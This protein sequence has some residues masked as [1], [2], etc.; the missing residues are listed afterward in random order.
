MNAAKEAVMDC[1]G[2]GAKEFVLCS[3]ARNLELISLIQ[4]IKGISTY[5]FPEERSAAFFAMGRSIKECSP[6]VIVTTSGTA[7]PELFPA[8]IESFYQSIP[9]ILLTADRPK[10]FQGIGSPQTIDQINIFGS[11]AQSEIKT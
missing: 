6:T 4:S 8:V 1:L 3:G 11:Y 10:R 9:L 5:N 7:V 2:L